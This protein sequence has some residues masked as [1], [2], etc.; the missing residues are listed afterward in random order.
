MKE[1][2]TFESG[3]DDCFRF[4]VSTLTLPFAFWTGNKSVFSDVMGLTFF[5]FFFPLDQHEKCQYIWRKMK[6]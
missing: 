1:E 2:H 3:F 6:R 5:S 4:A